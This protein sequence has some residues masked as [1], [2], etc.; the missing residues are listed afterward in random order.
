LNKVETC[1]KC[2]SRIS[3]RWEMCTVCYKK[4]RE[5]AKR[6]LM[7]G[8]CPKC[9][10]PKTVRW[11]NCIDCDNK[12]KEEKLEKQK[13]IKIKIETDKLKNSYCENCGNLK[14]V[15]WNTCVLCNKIT[16]KKKMIKKRKIHNKRVVSQTIARRPGAKLLSEIKGIKSEKA[17]IR[18]EF[19]TVFTMRISD[20][21]KCQWCSCSTNH[22][23]E[24]YI[25]S[26]D[27]KRY[28][29]LVDYAAK[30]GLKTLSPKWIGVIKKYCFQCSFCG[31][32]MNMT[33]HRL[34]YIDPMFKDIVRISFCPNKCNLKYN[35]TY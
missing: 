14:S 21:K 11:N 29:K 3:V 22:K 15:R 8:Y 4:E 16:F 34:Y 13:Q 31:N 25:P 23:K 30:Y 19:G 6:K 26:G 35:E 10:E 1:E 33:P 18:C 24:E 32:Y 27:Q 7:D 2:G 9:G 20:I 12:E 5:L 28:R 17:T